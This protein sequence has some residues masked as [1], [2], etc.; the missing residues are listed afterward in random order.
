MGGTGDPQL[1]ILGAPPPVHVE[2]V[3]CV[4]VPLYFIGTAVTLPAAAVEEMFSQP[5]IASRDALLICSCELR[6]LAGQRRTCRKE[7]G[8]VTQVFRRAPDASSLNIICN[9]QQ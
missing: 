5:V 3:A 7:A 6:S 4:S 1:L 9:L 2:P 8:V